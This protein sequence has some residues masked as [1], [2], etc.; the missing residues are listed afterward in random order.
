MR[1]RQEHNPAFR[2]VTVHMVRRW[3]NINSA[4]ARVRRFFVAPQTSLV[5]VRSTTDLG[6]WM[7]GLRTDGHSPEEIAE[8]LEKHY[9]HVTGHSATRVRNWFRD[10]VDGGPTAVQPTVTVQRKSRRKR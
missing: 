2:E 6:R 7:I 9:P 3:A 8:L 4:P 5:H 1:V 10:K